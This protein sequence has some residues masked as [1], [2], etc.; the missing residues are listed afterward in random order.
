MSGDFDFLNND[1]QPKAKSKAPPRAE[2]VD[3]EPLD[4]DRPSRS[5][6][7]RE[8]DDRVER[9]RDRSTRTAKK[10]LSPLLIGGI[11]LGALIIVGG[12]IAVVLAV[13][14]KDPDRK[15][16]PGTTPVAAASTR[17]TTTNS[18]KKEPVD[19]NSPSPDVVDKV[20]KATVRILVAYKNGKGASGSGFVEKDSRLVLT[21]AHVV[22]ML[23][24]KDMGPKEIELIV[25]SGEGDKEYALGGELLTVDKE[26][27]LAI[28]RPFIIDI[29]SRHIVPDGIVVPRASNVVELQKLYV[30]GFPLGDALG[31]EI[32]VRPTTVTSLRKEGGKLSKIQVEGGM[33]SGNSG[34]PVVDAKGNVVGVAVSGIKGEAI[35]FAIPGEMVQQLL[36]KH[37]K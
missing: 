11:A 16:K 18:A 14:G 7:A 29:G 36:A 20:K 25:N 37:R 24:P 26:N 1:E 8:R 35:N 19:A 2:P 33:T 12:G 3:D 34:G 5:R 15:D 6:Y 4:D 9:N 21:N 32:S 27:D 17:P 10:G 31:A 28:I 13:R 22:G 30:F 23:D